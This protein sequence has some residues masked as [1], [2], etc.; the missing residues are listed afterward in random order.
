MKKTRIR[1]GSVAWWLRGYMVAG[2][3]MAAMS[4]P[5]TIENLMGWI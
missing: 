4:L 5:S 1:E 2:V 3:F